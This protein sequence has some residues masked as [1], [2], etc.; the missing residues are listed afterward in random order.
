MDLTTLDERASTESIPIER[1]VGTEPLTTLPDFKGLRSALNQYWTEN[2][3]IYFKT[4]CI[5]H[6]DGQVEIQKKD[7]QTPVVIQFKAVSLISMTKK[8]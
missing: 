5:I 8:T 7:E 4:R 1:K 2:V 3:D 6:C